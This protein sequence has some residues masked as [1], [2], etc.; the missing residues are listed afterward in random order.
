MCASNKPCLVVFFVMVLAATCASADT[1]R[2][3]PDDAQIH[4]AMQKAEKMPPEKELKQKMTEQGAPQKTEEV[5]QQVTP[6]M[7]QNHAG[8]DIDKL[9]VPKQGIDLEKLAE[10]YRDLAPDKV[11]E[12]P[13]TKVYVFVSLGI[14]KGSLSRIIED[15][16]RAHSTLVL[17]G[18]VGG[19]I[20][21]TA[22]AVKDLVGEKK[23][24]WQIDPTKYEKYRVTQVPTTV[25]VIKE[26]DGCNKQTV[27]MANE[28]D[29]FSVE[30]DV[31][32]RY[33]LEQIMSARPQTATAAK[34]FLASLG[35]GK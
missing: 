8:K 19:S 28:N 11:A 25:L 18:L 22:H 1:L 5:F 35:G 20:K 24:G 12:E 27:C 15:A 16:E 2:A 34:P 10:K 33:A 7:L 14:P 30:G 32:L 3:I 23:V 29:Y 4:G 9:T 21:K 31:S 13:S 6:A 17:R 26:S